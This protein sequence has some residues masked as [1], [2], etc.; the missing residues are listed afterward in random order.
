MKRHWVSSNKLKPFGVNDSKFLNKKSKFFNKVNKAYKKALVI[1]EN[2][3]AIRAK[4]SIHSKE[5]HLNVTS[6][7]TSPSRYRTGPKYAGNTIASVICRPKSK[8]END[9]D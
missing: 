2:R 8:S 4:E 9:F 3:D 5:P 7:L 1:H 6:Y